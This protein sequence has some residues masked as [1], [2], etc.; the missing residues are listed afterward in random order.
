MP[1]STEPPIGEMDFNFTVYMS[2]LLCV[3]LTDTLPFILYIVVGLYIISGLY[4]FHSSDCFLTLRYLMLF[5]R[6]ND[7]LLQGALN[8]E[9]EG[10]GRKIFKLPIYYCICFLGSFHNS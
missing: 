10:R 9:G 4:F 8:W 7:T 1:C 2:S 6:I 5:F 3:E